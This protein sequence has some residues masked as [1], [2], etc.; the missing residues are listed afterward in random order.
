MPQLEQAALERLEPYIF[1]ALEVHR[2]NSSLS[3]K[4]DVASMLN[5]TPTRPNSARAETDVFDHREL[6]I[7]RLIVIAF[8]P[9]DGTGDEKS[10]HTVEELT[11][12]APYLP[13]TPLVPREKGVIHSEVIMPILA[14]ILDGTPD[15]GTPRFGEF[16][17]DLLGLDSSGNTLERIAKIG[18]KGITYTTGWKDGKRFG[19]PHAVY[20]SSEDLQVAAFFGITDDSNKLYPGILKR[21]FN[22]NFPS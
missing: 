11:F 1:N 10:G 17:L 15:D 6:R 16:A 5:P 12:P 18:G 14:Q 19:N 21:A 20:N 22:P 8:Q 13:L 2:A 9:G 4:S 7:G 3:W